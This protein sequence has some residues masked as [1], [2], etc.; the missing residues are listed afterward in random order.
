MSKTAKRNKRRI[1]KIMKAIAWFMGITFII[2]GLCIDAEGWI[3]E[4]IC[5]VSVLYLL[6]Y[7][8]ITDQNQEGEC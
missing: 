6:F 1:N 5:F 3:A 7:V 2:S 8:H 4:C